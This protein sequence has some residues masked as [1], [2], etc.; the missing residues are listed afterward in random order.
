MTGG[1]RMRAAEVSLTEE[2]RATLRSWVSAGR[3]ERRMAMRAEVILAL[4]EGLGNE[5]VAQR[6]ATRA[7][8]VSKWRGRFARARL[9]GLM[10]AARGGKP[11]RYGPDHERRI[12]ATLDQPPPAGY[13]RWDGTLLTKHLPDI[14]KDQVWRVLRRHKISLARRRSWCISTDPAFAQKA[15]DIVGLYLQ[16]PENAVVLSVDEKPHIQALERAQGWLKLP[17]GRAVTGFNHEYK[18][19]GTTTLFAALEVATGLVKAGHYRRRRRIE[20]L[21]FI[22]RVIAQ[23]PDREI[24]VILDNLNTHKPKHDRWLARHKNVHFHFTPTHASWLNQVEVWF[25]ILSGKALA[26]ASFTSPRQVRQHIDAFIESYNSDAH[27]FEWTKQTVYSQ[28][29]RSTYANLCN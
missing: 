24:H 18:R 19:H 1:T 16:P 11:K 29:P 13:R 20:F 6:L 22:N 23:Y 25:S 27:P 17:N 28:H 15:A 4:A 5:A 3:T 7:A 10:D 12:L 2:E 8:T 26:G 9:P 14:S 21:D